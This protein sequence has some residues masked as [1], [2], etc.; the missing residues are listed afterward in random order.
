MFLSDDLNRERIIYLSY[1]F[2]VRIERD[3]NATFALFVQREITFHPG[4]KPSAGIFYFGFFLKA[5]P[6]SL[7][8]YFKMR[9]PT[10]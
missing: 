5:D 3:P 8:Q 7:F 4:S 2:L 9:K 10:L 6:L 1:C